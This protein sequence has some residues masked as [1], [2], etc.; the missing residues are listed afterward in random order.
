MLGRA[1]VQYVII[2]VMKIRFLWGLAEASSTRPA[3]TVAALRSEWAEV[4]VKDIIAQNKLAS[5][6]L[7]LFIDVFVQEF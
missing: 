7:T 3:A 6:C 5:E 1:G 4:T 2:L